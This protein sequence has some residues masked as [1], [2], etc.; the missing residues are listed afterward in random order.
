MIKEF[1]IITICGSGRFLKEMQ[2]VEEKLTLDECI[3]LMIGVNTKDVART[4]ELQHYKPM[5]D[6]MHLAKIDISD[7]IFVVNPGGYIG[8]STMKEII[9]AQNQRKKVYSLESIEGI[10]TIVRDCSGKTANIM[11]I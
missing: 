10:F 6:K 2:K 7:A 8:E 1:R 4:E 5:L 9:Y 11:K 3:V